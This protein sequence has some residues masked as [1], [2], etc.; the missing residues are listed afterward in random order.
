M[1]AQKSA[2]TGAIFPEST[3]IM[4]DIRI[5]KENSSSTAGDGVSKESHA[6]HTS[7]TITGSSFSWHPTQKYLLST[8]IDS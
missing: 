2:V 5:S 1:V 3:Q 7:S 6:G 4:W 8:T